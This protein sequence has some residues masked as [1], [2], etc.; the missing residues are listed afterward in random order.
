MAHNVPKIQYKNYS[1]NGTTAIAS[2]IIT[3]I[4]DTSFIEAG[5][6]VRGTG[7]P[8]GATVVSKTSSTVTFSGT[9]AAA[10]GTVSIDYGFEIVFDYPPIES[11]G[12][13]LDPKET[14]TTSLSGVKQVI[15]DYIEEFRSLNFSFLSESIKTKMDTFARYWFCLGKTF[16][17]FDDKT[18]VSY[19]EYE[20]KDFKYLPVKIAPKGENIYVWKIALAFRRI[21]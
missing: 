6:F 7:V 11:N 18:S 10:N 1:Y 15:V 9:A 8:T 12:A 20:A 14:V 21:L 2:N 16:R 3:A 5:M 17:Y 13:Q 19:I 4:A